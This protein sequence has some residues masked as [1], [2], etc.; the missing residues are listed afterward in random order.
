MLNSQKYQKVF[1][2]EK[3][4]DIHIHPRP[5]SF[6]IET[7]ENFVDLCVGLG[8]TKVGFVEHGRRVSKKHQGILN[9]IDDILRFSK[10]VEPVKKKYSVKGVDVKCGIEIDYSQ[11][12][13]FM[14]SV[15]QDCNYSKQLDYIIGS[16]HGYSKKAYCEYLSAVLDLVETYEVDVLGHFL[17]SPDIIKYTSE[18]ERILA[19]I[20]RKH[21]CLE[22]NKAERYDC[23]NMHLKLYFL[24]MA[25]D[26]NV[27]FVFGSD[28]HNI[29]ELSINNNRKWFA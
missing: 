23:N 2:N 8:I 26:H 13:G 24:D 10:C 6:S 7:I 14:R 18:I 19:V 25:I 21:I 5:D 15:L 17:L 16:V 11:D 28:A 3:K 27:K 12:A 1:I 29:T 20:S 9:D 4:E 22:L